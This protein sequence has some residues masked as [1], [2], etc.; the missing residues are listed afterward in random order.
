MTA[1]A[2]LILD[3]RSR[4]NPAT[5]ESWTYQEIGAVLGISRQA[6][7]Q[8]IKDKRGRCMQCLRKLRRA[9]KFNQP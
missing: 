2:Q 4:L 8:H 6:A 5:G 3:L 1:T 9:P 7:T